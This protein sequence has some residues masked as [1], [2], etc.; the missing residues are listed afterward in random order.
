MAILAPGS[1]EVDKK[2]LALLMSDGAWSDTSV[3]RGI[4]EFA[5]IG[6]N[7]SLAEDVDADG[8]KSLECLHN[9]NS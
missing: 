9:V 4:F 2:D 5:E 3:F 8:A 1:P 7:L 6:A